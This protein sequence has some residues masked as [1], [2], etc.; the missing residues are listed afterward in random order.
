MKEEKIYQ[1]EVTVKS[2]EICLVKAKSKKQAIKIFRDGEFQDNASIYSNDSIFNNDEIK[3]H[4]L[5][6]GY[7]GDY[8]WS[9]ATATEIKE[10]K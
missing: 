2:V 10:N 7:G 5:G 8:L 6:S 4:I 9:G 1:V 3:T